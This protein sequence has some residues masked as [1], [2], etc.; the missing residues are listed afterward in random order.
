VQPGGELWRRRLHDGECCERALRSCSI[1]PLFKRF[2]LDE[3]DVQPLCAHL[4]GEF[5]T[6]G[7]LGDKRLY[8]SR[9]WLRIA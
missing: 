3:V 8:M 7:A 6:C 1:E 2:R 5:S 9:C 4:G